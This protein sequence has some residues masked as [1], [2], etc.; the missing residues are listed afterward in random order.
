MS[1]T[2]TAGSRPVIDSIRQKGSLWAPPFLN[3]VHSVSDSQSHPEQSWVVSSGIRVDY[4]ANTLLLAYFLTVTC[5]WCCE[6][7]STLLMIFFFF[8][9]KVPSRQ[10][11]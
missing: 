8:D 11:L 6:V 10:S 2:A 7:V 5:G 9:R 3:L 1:V 4:G